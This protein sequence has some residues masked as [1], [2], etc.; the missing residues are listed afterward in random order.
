MI[1]IVRWEVDYLKRFFIFVTGRDN[2]KIVDKKGIY[3]VSERHKNA[4]NK[5]SVGDNALLYITGES[6]FYG[7]YEIISEPYTDKKR[8]FKSTIS[9]PLRVNLKKIQ[10]FEE[11]IPIRPLINDLNFIKNKRRWNG[12]FRGKA[13]IEISKSDFEIIHPM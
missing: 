1:K 5:V 8:L 7:V 4:I 6:V 12:S 10:T 3:G 13:I 9:F 2:G 11:P